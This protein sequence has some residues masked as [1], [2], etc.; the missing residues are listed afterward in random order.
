M[1]SDPDLIPFDPPARLH[2]AALR[3]NL[4]EAFPRSA[5]ETAV[6]RI[7]GPF[8]DTLMVC[9]PDLIREMLVDKVD[10]VGR[11]TLTTK[12]FGHFL[13]SS[14][15]F[16]TA[17]ADWQWK[18]RVLNPMFRREWVL[19]FVP[20]F[21]ALAVRQSQRWHDRPSGEP[22]DVAR[23]VRQITLD[24]VFDAL[25]AEPTTV[26]VEAYEKAITDAFDAVPWEILLVVLSMPSWIPFPGR[27]RLF[28]ARDYAY[29]QVS[30]I[31]AARR[32]APT[33]Q[34]DLLNLL[35]DAR[36]PDG[37]EMS[38][39]EIVDNLITFISTGHEVSTQA[40]A[41]A[42][43]LLAKDE[44]SQ[45]RVVDEVRATAGE[46]P[47][48]PADVEHLVFTEQVALEA[49]RLYPPAPILLRQANVDMKL[50]TYPVKAGTHLQIP[51]YALHRN[52]RL[53]ENPNAFDPDRF[54]RDRVKQHPRYAY[55]PFGAG[56]RVCIG[57]S[58]A[59]LE[60]VVVLA[61]L[62]R[63]FRFYPVPGHK[64]K[65]IARVSLR[66]QGGMP[67]LVAP[68]SSADGRKLL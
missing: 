47:I 37:R 18:R 43:W 11:S 29:E 48:Q 7:W 60:I 14:S 52:V 26:D 27:R 33:A 38:D 20:T 22:I 67:L 62:V 31:V 21:A 10:Q 6:T 36:D 58:F 9:D 45:Q 32:A 16:V 23:A 13:G 54:A 51:I 66:V 17:G 1:L 2:F 28:R 41:W 5:Y 53:W 8:D 44:L 30:R 49:M 59:I 35:I 65:P 34:S 46:R 40:L 15:V 3:R 4:V 24:I 56:P 42:L 12:V 61:T 39:L 55:L 25:L 68:R 64:P 19:A 50:G 63:A 57:A